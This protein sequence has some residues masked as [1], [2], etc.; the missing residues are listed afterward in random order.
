VPSFELIAKDGKA[1]AGILKTSHGEIETPMFMAVATKGAV[2]TLSPEEIK[3]TGTGA[4]ISNAFHLYMRP[5]LE[6]IEK[7]G[8]LHRF[9][10]WDG[11]LFTD[12]GGFQ[13][14]RQGFFI[15]V[16]DEG[17]K[18][19]TE[20][21][22]IS[23]YTPE[24]SALTQMTLGSDIAMVLD[25]CPP[26]D[27]SIKRVRKAV[28]RT[29]KWAKEF[30][31]IHDKKE[32]GVFAIVQGTRYDGLREQCAHDLVKMDFDGY[33][34]GGLSIGES[35]EEM[36]KAIE[37]TTPLLPEEKP[38]YFMGLGSP[39]DLLD[40]IAMGIDVFDSALPTRNA[41]HGTVLTMKGQYNIKRAEFKDDMRPLEE[42]C[43]CYT[44]RNFSR[45]YIR[46]LFKEKEMLALRLL[47]IHNL[48]FMQRLMKK[49]RES[50]MEGRFEEF[51]KE[52]NR[53]FL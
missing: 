43:D 51:R 17:M 40:S 14:I 38:R 13:V 33:G 53:G 24:E 12:S 9:M 11:I 50:I 15:K 35:R 42:G 22:E 1:R 27:A 2:K 34:I 46:H 5:G 47:S 10:N 7:H 45:A 49:A 37:K 20:N 25:E 16:T 30:R 23:V 28:E 44:C 36:L 32:Q 39:V 41:R 8:G 29:T 52:F 4:L 19:H 18:Y 6:L 21:G 48:R 31:E 26:H 3:E